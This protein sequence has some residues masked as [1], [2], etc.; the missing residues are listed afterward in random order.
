MEQPEQCERWNKVF[1]NMKTRN[2]YN[3]KKYFYNG[4]KLKKCLQ[5]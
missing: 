3:I 4:K 2:Y 5:K 1:K